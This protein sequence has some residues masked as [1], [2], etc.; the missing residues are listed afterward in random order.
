MNQNLNCLLQKKQ[1][2]L[3]KLHTYTPP[4]QI[5]EILWHWMDEVFLKNTKTFLIEIHI[6]KYALGYRSGMTN[7]SLQD[8]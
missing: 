6:T 4:R 7:S 3:I 2:F 1:S 5:E 8:H